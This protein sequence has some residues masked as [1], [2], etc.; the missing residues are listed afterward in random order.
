M[1]VTLNDAI[2]TIDDFQNMKIEPRKEII[3]PWLKEDSI[4]LISGW[5]GIGKSWF[6]L[7]ML[8]SIAGGVSFGPWEV[9]H[10]LPCLFLDGEMVKSDLQERINLLHSH[11]N[12]KSPFYIYS[13]AHA[14]DIGLPRAHLASK[15]FQKNIKESLLARGIKILVVDNLAS[16]ASGLDENS[17][18]DWD[19]I[20]NW[21]LDLRFE[22]IS[23]VLLHHTGKE[24]SQRGTSAR[25]DNIDVSIA[26]KKPPNYTPEDGARFIVNFEKNR[27]VATK[28]LSLITD[29]EFTLTE[30]EDGQAIWTWRSVK[31]GKKSQILKLLDQGENYNTIVT[32]LGIT[33]GYITKVKNEAINKGYMD[34]GS[35]LTSSGHVLFD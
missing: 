17:K 25:E 20:N 31:P 4:I 14:N 16:L 12:A 35:K 18:K 2:I 15:I 8:S 21:L 28:D 24:G 3:S 19:P 9:K 5:R 29:I 10:S 11:Q 23:T 1:L 7:S 32:D 22:G 34:D 33:K 30:D 26:L 27:S 6:G 13:C